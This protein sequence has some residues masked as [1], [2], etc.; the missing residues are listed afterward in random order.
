MR[1]FGSR[2]L[3]P[4]LLLLATTAVAPTAKAADVDLTG[5]RKLVFVAPFMEIEI[6]IA[7]VKDDGGKLK[8]D[9]KSFQ[10]LQAPKLSGIQKKDDAISFNVIAGDNELSFAGKA[11]K[12][13]TYLGTLTAQGMKLPARFE[14]TKNP[15]VSPPDQKGQQALVQ[16]YNK[17]IGMPD[18]K[19]RVKAL[20]EMAAASQGSPLMSQV[21]PVIL[22]DAEVAGLSEADVNA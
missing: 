22:R 12:D 20:K 19:A 16:S 7:D 2:S 6:L 9:V 11:A 3:S 15:R 4:L 17:A 5:T 10:L 1:A 13:G 14:A 8:A 21:Y 18:L